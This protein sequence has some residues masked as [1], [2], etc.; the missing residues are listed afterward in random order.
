RMVCPRRRSSRGRAPPR[1]IGGGGAC[2]SVLASEPGAT[3]LLGFLGGA[4]GG[5]DQCASV[6]LLARV[7]LEVD[8]PVRVHLYGEPREPG[9]L[10]ALV[11]GCAGLHVPAPRH[12]GLPVPQASR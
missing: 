7:T 3:G 5:P 12:G 4:P 1:V 6:G 10:G 2:W 11:G 9:V 8:R